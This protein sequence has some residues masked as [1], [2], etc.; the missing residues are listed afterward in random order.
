MLMAGKKL[1]E[2]KY[3][4]SARRAM[5]YFRT[6]PDLVE[7]KPELSMLSHYLG[8]MMDALAQLGED[9]LAKK[10]LK[11]ASDLQAEDGSIPAYPGAPWVC[12]T[13]L[14]QLSLAWYRLGMNEPADKC[15]T[16]LEK[17]QRKKR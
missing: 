10:G 11:Q 13:G 2:Q 6:K 15:M 9:E 14:A 1:N 3:T 5:D 8:Y 16:Y 7:F 4:D 12:A 17:V